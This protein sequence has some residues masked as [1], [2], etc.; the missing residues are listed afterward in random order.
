MREGLADRPYYTPYLQP[1]RGTLVGDAVYF[2][3]RWGNPIVKY[4][5]GKNCLSMV[6]PPAED[7][8]Y[9]SLM[10]MENNSLGF[11][12]TRDSSLHMWSRKVDTEEAADWV[13]YRVIELEKTIHVA[14][15]DGI[16]VVVG[17][18]EGV[19]VIFIAT[20]VGLFMIKLKS[21]LVRKVGE[22]GVYFS[23]LPYMSF[24][25]PDRGRLLSLARTN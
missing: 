5:L 17:F 3:V 13:Q 4:D 11:A 25:T 19:G 6:D 9:I 18:A 7:V 22:A 15:P 12:C 10:V 1:R 14:N 8:Y 24:Y 20:C 2:T 21:G 23:V 16:P